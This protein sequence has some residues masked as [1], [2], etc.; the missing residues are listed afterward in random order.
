MLLPLLLV[1]GLALVLIAGLLWRRSRLPVGRILTSDAGARPGRLLV[2][3]HHRLHGRPDYL[4][5]RGRQVIP[6][7][8]KPTQTRVYP[9]AVMQLMAYCLLVEEHHGRPRHGVLVLAD[10]AETIPYTDARRTEL[11]TLLATMR[12]APP[13]PSRNH[14]HPGRC[15]ACAFARV[16]SEALR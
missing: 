11:L 6:V 4:I 15:R 2:S 16:C 8:V 5:R 13:L 12:A 1:V 10:R 9:S 3:E 7:E 14:D